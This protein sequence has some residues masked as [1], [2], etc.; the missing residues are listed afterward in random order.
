[1]RA[2]GNHKI[3]FTA[4]LLLSCVAGCGDPDKNGVVGPT[5]LPTVILVTPPSATAGVCPN[6]AI[7]SATFSKAMNPATITSSTFTLTAPGG[8]SVAGAVTYN[9][10]TNIA[11]FKPASS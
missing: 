6:S 11:T 9:A 7:I 8:A 2:H 10:T 3:W 1:M 5:T 4:L